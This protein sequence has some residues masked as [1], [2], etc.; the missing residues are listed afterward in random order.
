MKII[1]NN[2]KT[3][4]TTDCEEELALL[5]VAREVANGRDSAFLVCDLSAISRNCREILESETVRPRF[6]IFCNC[7]PVVLRHLS[8]LGFEFR[9][10]YDLILHSAIEKNLNVV[11]AIIIFI[12]LTL[13]MFSGFPSSDV[14]I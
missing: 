4:T 5:D 1:E 3:T 11:S 14:L 12:I 13:T 8:D 10:R 7:A 2:T 6:D 9:A